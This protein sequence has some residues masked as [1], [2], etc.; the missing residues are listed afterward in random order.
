MLA[1]AVLRSLR[2]RVGQTHSK[3]RNVGL[4]QALRRHKPDYTRSDIEIHRILDGIADGIV[5]YLLV[6]VSN[7]PLGTINYSSHAPCFM[8]SFRAFHFGRGSGSRERFRLELATEGF[9]VRHMAGLGTHRAG[10]LPGPGA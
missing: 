6:Q 4:P 5:V 3:G 10:P 9:G 1:R 7:C 8:F 2:G